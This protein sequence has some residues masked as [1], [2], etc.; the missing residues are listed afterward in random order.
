MWVTFKIINIIVSKFSTDR[1]VSPYSVFFFWG[2]SRAH[3]MM[4]DK[5]FSKTGLLLS[6]CQFSLFLH[7]LLVLIII[8]SSLFN[9][10]L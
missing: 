3:I 2:M 4:P 1:D 9:T 5:P 8:I 10:M 6:V 7:P